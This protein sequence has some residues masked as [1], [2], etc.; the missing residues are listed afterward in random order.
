LLLASSTARCTRVATVEKNCA[1]SAE[2]SSI[3]ISIGSPAPVGGMITQAPPKP[4]SLLWS[5][6]SAIFRKRSA[7]D[8]IWD[9]SFIEAST[10]HKPY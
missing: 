9:S 5:M 1:R 8:G 4:A 6:R 7:F 3:S 10:L 2:L